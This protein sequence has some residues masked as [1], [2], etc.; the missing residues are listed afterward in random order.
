MIPATTSVNVPLIRR[1]MTPEGAFVTNRILEES[2]AEMLDELARW[3][4]DLRSV[5]RRTTEAARAGT[6][7]DGTEPVA[8]GPRRPS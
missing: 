4:A 8:A 3:A 6:T 2:G 1:M 5:G 7:E